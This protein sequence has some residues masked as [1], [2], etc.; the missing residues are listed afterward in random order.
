M[1]YYN[2]N[3]AILCMPSYSHICKILPYH[4]YIIDIGHSIAIYNHMWRV[5]GCERADGHACARC[6]MRECVRARVRARAW[7]RPCMHTIYPGRWCG[8]V[9]PRHWRGTVSPNCCRS[10]ARQCSRRVMMCHITGNSTEH[11]ECTA[12][13]RLRRPDT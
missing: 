2:N 5:R 11:T 3:I 12:T 4:G 1:V 10:R 13:Q 6:S 7:M 8:Q 9:C